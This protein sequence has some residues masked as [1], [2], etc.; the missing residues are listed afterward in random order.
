MMNSICKVSTAT[1]NVT[2]LDTEFKLPVLDRSRTVRIYLPP[3]Y[4]RS[5]Q[6]YPVVYMHDGQNLFDAATSFC[7]EWAVDESLNQLHRET[8]LSIIAV[9]IDNGAEH[10]I[11]ELSPWS[12]EEFGD[13]EGEEYM[14]FV[15][16]TVKPHIDRNYR[17]LSDKQH[18]AIMGSSM[19]GLISHYAAFHY[20]HIFSK[21]GI[22]SPS[23]WFADEVF[24]FSH[25]DKLDP[26][27]R[28]YLLA[29]GAESEAMVGGFERML[30]QLRDAGLD[31]D[32][33]R[34]KLVD[35]YGHS[36]SFWR[37]EFPEAI[38]WLFR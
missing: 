24:D 21:A 29:G 8:G 33:L 27:S 36:E 37:A 20:P 26:D 30:K 16:N 31:R 7:G 3:G 19:G 32:R 2:V 11:R 14:S 28:L 35:G 23:Y 1:D 12:N 13:A 9:G 38:A 17:T 18:T 22:F 25:A 34:S 15:V 10:R 4:D 5:E 6:A